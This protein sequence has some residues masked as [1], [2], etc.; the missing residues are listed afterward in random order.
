MKREITEL[1]QSKLMTADEAVKIVKSGDR[2]YTGTA[3]SGAYALM[4]ALWNRRHELENVT[5][6]SSNVYQYSPLYDD[7]EDH[8]FHYNTY[9]MGINERKRLK[10]GAP[11]TFNSIHLSRIDLWAHDIAKPDVCMFEVSAPDED[12]YM[13]FGPSGVALHR[14]LQDITKK[15][16]VQVNHNTPYVLGE[17]TKIHVSEVDAIVEADWEYD[18]Y[19]AGEPD[20]LSHQIAAH[21]LK[22]IPDA[23]TIQLGLGNISIAIGYG[24][25][26]KN[27]LG[28]YTEMLAQPM[29]ELIQSGNVTNKYKGYF[30]GK[31]VYGFTFGNHELYQALDHNEDFY[32]QPF[33]VVNDPRNIAKNK[34]MISINSA[35]AIDLY[36]EAAADC[37]NWKQQSGVGGQLDF[38]RG[39][40]WSEGG[41]SIIALA[42][43]FMKNGKR[44]SKI[45]PFFGPG[46]AVTT[47]RSD[48]HYVATEYG[49]V[50]LR[51]LTMGDRARAMISL[52]HPDF[53]EELTS[54]AKAAGLI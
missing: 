51:E 37:M 10:S 14:C 15:T 27:D 46:T 23:A 41:K 4:E 26:E 49:C 52:A 30:D 29:Y 34:N 24:L 1:Y 2:V 53:R 50:N 47:G 13:S 31:T 9:F 12:G 39:A 11:I 7:L 17:D 44:I 48:I 21:V 45:V 6:M 42:S 32:A 43:S 20:E 35:M 38:V 54:H 8:P 16:I 40:Q 3:S 19:V 18:N 28:I 25:R 36:G 5:I 33:T 22:E